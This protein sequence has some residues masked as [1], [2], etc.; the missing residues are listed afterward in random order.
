MLLVE[1]K[2][3]LRMARRIMGDAFGVSV[4]KVTKTGNGHN[5]LAIIDIL[6]V[7]WS[8]TKRSWIGLQ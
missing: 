8:P 7:V 5:L 1:D 6:N 3:D 2:V 4:R